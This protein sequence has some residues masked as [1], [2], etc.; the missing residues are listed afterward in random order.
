MNNILTILVI[1]AIGIVGYMTIRGNDAKYSNLA[2]FA[3]CLAEKEVT[4]YGAEWCSHCK[5]EKRAFGDAWKY[6]KYVECPKNADL[7]AEKKI[8]GYPTWLFLN[9]DR[10]EGEQGVE[11]LS[12]ATGCALRSL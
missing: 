8:T 3:Q 9:G 12:K 5:N 7:C 6:V 1:V 11:N 2:E 4:M 10:L